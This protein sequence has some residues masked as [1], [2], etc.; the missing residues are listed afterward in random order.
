MD[1]RRT[2]WVAL[3]LTGIF[4]TAACWALWSAFQPP[5]AGTFSAQ[6]RIRAS[7]DPAG[8]ELAFVDEEVDL[9]RVATPIERDFAYK[10]TSKH[11]VRIVGVETS[12]NCLVGQSE[13]KLL[14]PGE[15]GRVTLRADARKERGLDQ[16]YEVLVLYEGVRPGRARLLVRARSD[17]DEVVYTQQVRIRSRKGIAAKATLSL[18]DYRDKPLVI[19][20]ISTSNKELFA[21]VTEPPSRYLPGWKYGIEATFRGEHLPVGEYR[22]SIVLHTSDPQRESLQTEVTIQRIPRFRVAP[23]VIQLQ[24]DS[25]TPTRQSGELFLDDTGGEEIE[26]AAVRPSNKA[27]TCKLLQGGRSRK[28]FI[29]SCDHAAENEAPLSICFQMI[30]PV[31][32][33]VCV[34]V[35]L[36]GAK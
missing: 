30:K 7:D 25:Q 33:E 22:E 4:L 24:I 10:N 28:H 12:C 6:S 3:P 31:E 11:D 14:K 17:I 35:T 1:R 16:S 27:L 34:P 26:I 5:G 32:E 2:D 19:T 18:V 8:G 15:V 13:K 21:A 36:A 20:S 29:V 9:G 23:E